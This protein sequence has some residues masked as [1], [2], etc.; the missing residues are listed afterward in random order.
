MS[1]DTRNTHNRPEPD[2]DEPQIYA[3]SEN[4]QGG[5]HFSRRNFLAATAAGSCVGHVSSGS[6]GTHYWYPN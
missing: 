6:G 1:E 2:D 5:L 4:P 3:V